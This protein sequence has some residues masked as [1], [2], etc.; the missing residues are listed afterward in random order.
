MLPLSLAASQQFADGLFI[1]G[2]A[3][4]RTPPQCA[5]SQDGRR[6]HL[7]QRRVIGLAQ[8][9]FKLRL[10]IVFLFL[11]GLVAL[12]DLDQGWKS[13]QLGVRLLDVLD[14]FRSPH[15]VFAI[16]QRIQTRRRL[17]GLGGT[18]LASAQVDQ[19]SGQHE[20]GG[21][22]GAGNNPKSPLLGRRG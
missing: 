5:C 7:S 9:H 11:E 18:H 14:E 16:S 2:L 17:S 13:E 6:T 20:R 8:G 22:R 1:L 10:P 15:P 12:A 4:C 21:S 3:G 19:Q